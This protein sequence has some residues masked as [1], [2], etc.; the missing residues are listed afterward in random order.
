MEEGKR[1][2]K[3]IG[4]LLVSLLQLRYSSNSPH[5]LLHGPKQLSDV[6]DSTALDVSVVGEEVQA[7]SGVRESVRELPMR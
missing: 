1:M 4:Q 3:S 5:C 2:L 6:G 7:V